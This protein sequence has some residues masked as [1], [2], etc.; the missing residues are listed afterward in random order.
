MSMK[1]ILSEMY[2]N[3]FDSVSQ[4]EKRLFELKKQIEEYNA[5]DLFKV[6]IVI[7]KSLL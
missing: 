3:N 7:I 2:S 6:N 4:N 5:A 1:K